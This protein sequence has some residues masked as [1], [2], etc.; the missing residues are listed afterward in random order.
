MRP[1][2]APA[3]AGDA[4]EAIIA[5]LMTRRD[6]DWAWANFLPTV[7]ALIRATE[8]KRVME[9]GGGRSPSFGRDEVE[10]LGIDYVSND[11]SAREL[12]KAPAWAGR[13]HFDIQSSDPAMILP[14]AGRIDLA[15]SKMVMEHVASYRRAYANIFGLLKEGGI[16]I[17]FHPVLYALP[18]VLNRL[19]P[20]AASQ[21]LLRAVF[22]N[23][24]DEGVPKFPAYYSGCVIS[25][26]V[27][28]TLREIGFS[29]VWQIPFYGHRYYKRIPGL[30][31]AHGRFTD[32][33]KKR[34]MTRFASFAFTV[35]RK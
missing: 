28:T 9:I 22:P 24:T 13:A 16:A 4:A 35:V 21:R 18:F 6:R 1:G 20:E 8:A 17:S 3:A 2:P 15:F 27:R 14:F 7:V 11:I 19:A 10:A 29:G 5:G 32:Y 12:D 31:A 30:R 25:E 34:G 26:R 33:V 23:R